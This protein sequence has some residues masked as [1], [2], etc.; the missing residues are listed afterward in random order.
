MTITLNDTTPTGQDYVLFRA[1]DNRATYISGSHTDLVSD[2]LLVTS[3]PPKRTATSYGNRRSSA[4]LIRSVDVLDPE[5]ETV[6]RDAKLEVIASFPVG[7]S[8]A[9]REEFYARIAHLLTQETVLE[10]MFSIGNIEI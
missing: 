1:V 4:N 7:M 2:Q 10:D 6:K 5:G 3:V 9:D 8:Q